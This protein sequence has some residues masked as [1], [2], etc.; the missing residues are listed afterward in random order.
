MLES[1]QQYIMKRK[2]CSGG[3]VCLLLYSSLLRPSGT[4]YSDTQ[5]T[6]QKAL[7][8]MIEYDYSL[9]PV[10]DANKKLLGIVTSD[11]IL[12]ALKNFGVSLTELH[13]SHAIVKV[14]QYRPDEDL[15]DLLYDLKSTYAV[16]IT[17]A[18]ETLI[19]IVTST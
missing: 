6:A 8:L 13:V 17:N 5:D 3:N 9:L 4:N 14:D 15:L 2:K 1:Q 11:S 12:R 7:P 18:E 10:I 19:G 16:L